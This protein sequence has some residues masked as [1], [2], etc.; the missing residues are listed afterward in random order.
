MET[1]LKKLYSGIKSRVTS[2]TKEKAHLYYGLEL[3]PK[4]EFIDFSLNS[5]F[6]LLYEAWLSSGKK[7][8]LVP[9]IDRIDSSKGYILSNIRWVTLS[10]NSKHVRY[11]L[12]YVNKTSKYIGVS[13][14]K[15]TGNWRAR[16]RVNYKEITLGTFKSE[17]EAKHAYDNFKEVKHA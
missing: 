6:P 14:C 8:P 7:R 12:R 5:N 11:E 4:K 2:S 10:E 13:R 16:A 9:S 3:L 15:R 17:A 1:F